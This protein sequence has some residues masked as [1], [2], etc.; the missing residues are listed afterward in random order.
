MALYHVLDSGT[1][2]LPNPRRYIRTSLYEAQT[3]R[4]MPSRISMTADVH[5][6]LQP[7]R[8]CR[9][10]PNPKPYSLKL[11]HGLSCTYSVRGLVRAYRALRAQRF[12]LSVPYGPNASFRGDLGS[13]SRFRLQASAPGGKS[14]GSISMLLVASCLGRRAFLM[15]S[16]K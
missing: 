5:A 7:Y 3:H 1:H 9:Q 16:P 8:L 12:G 2:S 10:K 14:L 4:A 6:S 11:Q 13:L 15:S